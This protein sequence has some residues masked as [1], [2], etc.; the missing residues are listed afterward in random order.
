MPLALCLAPAHLTQGTW[1]KSPDTMHT[2][3]LFGVEKYFYNHCYLCHE[4]YVSERCEREISMSKDECLNS[5]VDK[6]M[7]V[8]VSKKGPLK[9]RNFWKST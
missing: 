8:Y 5:T 2:Y 3:C 6:F 7:T 9:R 1:S 4:R